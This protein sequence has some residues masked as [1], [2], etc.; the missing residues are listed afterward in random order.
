MV[1]S[2]TQPPE[3]ESKSTI[4]RH[5]GSGQLSAFAEPVTIYDIDGTIRNQSSVAALNE[6]K[7]KL[8]FQ[9]QIH[10]KGII[11]KGHCTKVCMYHVHG[12]GLTTF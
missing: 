3:F 12:R 7:L 1:M 8:Y 5:I 10:Y 9:G 2:D 6:G 11:G 4:E